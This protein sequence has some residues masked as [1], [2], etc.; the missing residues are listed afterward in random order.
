MTGAFR[1][2]A[3][4]GSS[5]VIGRRDYVATVWS[6]S[7]LL[8]LLGPLMMLS[9]G[10]L[11]GVIGGRSDGTALQPVVAVIA[12]T[13][14]AKPLLAAYDRLQNRGVGLPAIRVEAPTPD[15][16]AQARR[17]L[18]ARDSTASVVLTGWPSAPRLTG[19]RHQIDDLSSNVRLIIE[20]AAV[21]DALAKAGVA[22]PRAEIAE[23]VVDPAGGATSSARH[24]VA[25][26]AQTMLFML[27]ILLAGMLLSNLVEEKSNKVIE[28]LAAA[29]PVDAIFLGKLVAMLG[30]SLTGIAIWGGLIAGAIVAVLPADQPVPLPATGW[31]VFVLLGALYYVMNYMILGGLFLGIGAQAS[32]VREVQTISMPV[33]M[34]QLAIFGLGSAVVGDLDSP[35]GLFAA[36]FPLSSPIT[37][38]ARA[39]QDAVLWPHLLALVWQALWVAAIIRFA[40]SRFRSGVL[41]SGGPKRGWFRRA[42]TA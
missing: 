34:A 40:A 31:P 18:T 1:A 2:R 3:A 10:G 41:K 11:F 16:G 17:I 15:T 24:I 30:V 38:I 37:M 23:T 13:D 25:R 4:I 12:G 39:A 42:R 19:P 28:V 6:R 32:T 7:F 14:A 29:V 26:G 36:A 27:T 22:R 33:T 5:L 8:F 20:D 9:F 35:L 21:N